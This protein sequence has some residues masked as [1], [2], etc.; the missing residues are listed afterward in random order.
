MVFR[1]L[2]QLVLLLSS[3]HRSAEPP[4]HPEP[5]TVAPSPPGG[6]NPPKKPP[7]KRPHDATWTEIKLLPGRH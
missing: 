3:P 2:L 7:E 6:P 5:V 4:L 1:L